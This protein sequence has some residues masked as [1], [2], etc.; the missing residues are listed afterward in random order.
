MHRGKVI[1]EKRP[2][3]KGSV[4]TLILPFHPQQA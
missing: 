1:A 3:E 2:D 4:F